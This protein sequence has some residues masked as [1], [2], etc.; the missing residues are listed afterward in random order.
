METHF[1][2]HIVLLDHRPALDVDVR[3]DVA[4][5]PQHDVLAVWRPGHVDSAWLNLERARRSTSLCEFERVSWA[6][7]RK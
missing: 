2:S 7:R 4:L 5:S 3:D 6:E 1:A